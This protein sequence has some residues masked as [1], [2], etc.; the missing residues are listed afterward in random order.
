LLQLQQHNRSVR[1]LILVKGKVSKDKR[2]VIYNS[3]VAYW[4]LNMLGIC[5]AIK[6]GI[7]YIDFDARTKKGKGTSLRNHG[8]KFRIKVKDVGI[9][10]ENTQ[11]II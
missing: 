10:Y 6:D 7:I 3:A 11:I 2:H 1:R 4:D 5:N 9:I 8:T